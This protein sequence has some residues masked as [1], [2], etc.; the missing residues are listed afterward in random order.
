[1]MEKAKRDEK[2][3][4]L[5]EELHAL[6]EDAVANH[7]GFWRLDF[8]PDVTGV[9][10]NTVRYYLDR[11][12]N[13]YLMTVEEMN[14]T[15]GQIGRRQYIEAHPGVTFTSSGQ[16]VNTR[17]RKVLSPAEVAARDAEESRAAHIMTHDEWS[18]RRGKP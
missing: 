4:A 1:M 16:P 2:M 3:L 6:A 9:F 10:M 15:D 18:K 8:H 7:E 11:K 12:H 5:L 14:L 13:D 17:V